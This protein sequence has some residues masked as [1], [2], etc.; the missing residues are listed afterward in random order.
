MGD[1]TEIV[2][3]RD[4]AV[5]DARAV[6]MEALEQGFVAV[7]VVGLLPNNQVAFNKSKTLDAL[8]FIGA[9]EWVKIEAIKAWK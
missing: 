3:K 9:L 4:D 8:K 7:A 2:T 6:L 5:A 1:V